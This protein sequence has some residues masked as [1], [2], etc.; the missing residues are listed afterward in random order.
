MFRRGGRAGGGIMT[1]VE[2]PKRGHV[3]GPGSYS[4]D[5]KENIDDVGGSVEAFNKAF[6][7]L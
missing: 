3:D 7:K 1:G 4:C 6:P 5:M 2:T